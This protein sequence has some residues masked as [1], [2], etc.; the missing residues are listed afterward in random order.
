MEKLLLSIITILITASC[1]TRSKTE[2]QDAMSQAKND[3]QK[4]N[5]SLHSGEMVPVRNTYYE[6]LNNYYK[7]K[8]YF[9]DSLE[10]YRCYDSIMLGLLKE[11]YGNH[12]LERVNSLTDSLEKIAKDWQKDA[13]FP[14][15]QGELTNFIDKE[16]KKQGLIP[17]PKGLRIFVGFEVDTNGKIINPL[18]RRGISESIDKRIIS[19]I[20]NMPYW[21]PAYL[22]G[23]PTKQT[24]TIPISIEN[25]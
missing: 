5:Y 6:V 19:I 20:N 16:L 23:K 11:K 9:T 18:I 14:G 2:C 4:A 10:Y 22:L 15:G 8:W 1:L 17:D 12:F 13:L 7:I 24:W 25:K 3:Y 21:E